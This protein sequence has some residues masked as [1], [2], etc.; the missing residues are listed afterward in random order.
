MHMHKHES[1]VIRPLIT[2]R[3]FTATRI[4]GQRRGTTQIR[5]DIHM[6]QLQSLASTTPPPTYTAFPA[7]GTN[8][9]V[10]RKYYPHGAAQATFWVCNAP[11][12]L[13]EGLGTCIING[14]S[15]L[16]CLWCLR[17]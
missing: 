4:L 15:G 13:H 11:E 2:A 3:A 10:P 9:T 17:A 6:K 7:H 16:W 8:P 5:M 12:P 1:I 14:W